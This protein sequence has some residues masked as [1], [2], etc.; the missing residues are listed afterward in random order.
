MR[1]VNRD[2]KK[3][4]NA[5]KAKILQ[6]FFKTGKGEYGE[7]DIFLG[8][9]VPQQRAI[10]R[11]HWNRLDISGV[12]SFLRSNIHEKRLVAL[13]I[14]I[15]K[16]N[17]SH[18]GAKEI[19]FKF[20]LKNTKYINNWDLVDLSAPKI[21]GDWL[22]DKKDRKILYSLAKSENLWDKRIAIISTFTFIRKGEFKDC[23]DISEILL[24][25]T[26]DLIHKAVG[27]MLREIGKKNQK[28]EEKF[29]RKHYKKMPRTMLRYAIERFPEEKRK[30]YM[31][32]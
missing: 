11:E 31:K 25:D 22:A 12:E 8:V 32:K 4:A 19:L 6:G 23:L 3:L 13:L 9:S 24:K 1:F 2:L 29:L 17:R 18:E 15:E 14:L 7:G 27:W 26:H 20:Y 5:E 28:I 10:A 21:I 30:F 16:Y